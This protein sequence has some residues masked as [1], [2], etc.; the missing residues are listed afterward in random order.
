LLTEIRDKNNK[1]IWNQ[2]VTNDLGQFTSYNY[3][4]GAVNSRTYDSYY[5]P[6]KINSKVGSRVLND[7]DFN[8][9]VKGNLTMRKDLL[10]SNQTENFTY[11]GLNRLTTSSNG[12]DVTYTSD[13]TGNLE[14]KSDVGT[15]QYQHAIKKHAVTSIQNPYSTYQPAVESITYTKFNKVEEIEQTEGIDTKK[16][17]F[18]YGA[19]YLRKRSSLYENGTK[20]KSTYYTKNAYE[21]KIDHS[22][23]VEKHM[24]Y[25]SAPS[26]AAAVFIS[27]GG[28]TGDLY[29]VHT[30]YLGS[31]VALSNQTG[32][33]AEEYAYDAWGNRRLASNWSQ[34]DTR[35][36]LLIDRGYT[37]HEHITGF[38]LVNMNGRV[39][40]PKL[41]RFLSPDPVLQDA[42]NTQNMN[43][44]SY[45]LNNPLKYIDPS[46]YTNC[47]ANYPSGSLFR[48]NTE[49]QTREG[50]GG[51]YMY[52]RMG[53]IYNSDGTIRRAGPEFEDLHKE[54]N[55]TWVHRN[56]YTELTGDEYRRARMMASA[57]KHGRA[58][59]MT[60]DQIQI[61]APFKD[62]SVF[63]ISAGNG[64]YTVSDKVFSVI[65]EAPSYDGFELGPVGIGFSIEMGFP[66]WLVGDTKAFG[67]DVGLVADN[68]LLGIG[69]Y[70]TKKTPLNNPVCFSISATMSY[71]QSNTFRQTKIG[72]LQGYG[73]EIMGAAGPAG[74]AIGWDMPENYK[75][76]STGGYGVG[77]ELGYGT[78]GTYTTVHQLSDL[79]K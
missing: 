61:L 79:F 12:S 65:G 17:E 23:G 49:R 43:R 70:V 26:G 4:N 14:T 71:A 69:V 73:V 63:T 75:M 38:G 39:Y 5:Q 58:L 46:G 8:I 25:I 41:G 72:D 21:V 62:G 3:G 52:H 37:M 29:F 76:Y 50:G 51:G 36:N 59:A 7:W 78:W 30:D 35:S 44:Y 53:T 47:A 2:A 60:T 48:R 32:Y 11:D 18:A 27:P 31:I 1:L 66:N 13:N 64:T 56:N 55:G 16:M 42:G 57:H 24:H 33:I 9:D 40:D 19:D 77:I 34:A 68:T 45:V 28:S 22:S 74:Y 15:Y 6:D 54:I 67:Y 20:K 10:H